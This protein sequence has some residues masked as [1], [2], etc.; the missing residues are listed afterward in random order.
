MKKTYDNKG[1]T[2]VE[3]IVVITI[4]AILWTIAFV[5]F[6]SYIS[7][8]RDTKRVSD[9]KVIEKWLEYFAI[10][11]NFYPNPTNWVFI[12]YSWAIVWNQWT[13]WNTTYQNID[14]ITPKPVDPITWLEYT[15]SVNNLKTEYQLAW[16]LEN[17]LSYNGIIK[18][19]YA[20]TI[21]TWLWFVRWNYNWKYLTVTTW[22]I[23]YVLA[24][25]SIISSDLSQT[26]VNQIVS[27]KNLVFNYY[28]NLP[29][30]YK[31]THYIM[32]GW[33]NYNPTDIVLFKWS[34]LNLSKENEQLAFAT[35]LKNVYGNSIFANE[36]DY[37]V[38]K[39][40]NPTINPTEA[41]KTVQSLILN[42]VW[43][44]VIPNFINII[45]K[46]T[47]NRYNYIKVTEDSISSN[48]VYWITQDNSN[49]FW[50]ATVWWWISKFDWRNWN[51][52]TTANNSQLPSNT[53]YWTIKD[54]NWNIWFA[55]SAGLVKYNWTTWIKYT[56][57]STSGWLISNTVYA[58]TQDS[59]WSIWVWTS[60]W[61]SKF[62]GT[63]WTVY[64]NA[65]TS[66]WLANNTVN[67]IT[68]WNNWEIWFA[69]N[70]WVSRFNG[71]TWT[72]YNTSN[73]SSMIWSNTTRHIIKDT[74]WN[75]WVATASW[76]SKYNWTIWSKFTTSNSP[77]F[78][79]NSTRYVFQ[80]NSWNIWIATT[81]WI[82]MYNWSVWVKY[83]TT[84]WLVLN[85][86]MR[87]YQDNVWNIRFGTNW[88][89][90]S[91]YDWISWKSIIKSSSLASNY[92]NT[93]W[94]QLDTT[95][96]WFGTNDL[97]L[98]KL[99]INWNRTI[100]DSNTP[101]FT[102]NTIYH[103]IKDT[104][105]NIWVA[106]SAGICKRNWTAWT[107]YTTMQWLL[108]NS[109]YWV[110]KDTAWIMWI[111]T[112]SGL[113]SYNWTAFINYTTTHGLSVNT[114]RFVTVDSSW[115][116]WIATTNGLNKYNKLTNKFYII[117]TS[118]W[119]ASNSINKIHFEWWNIW[120]ATNNWVSKWI[121]Q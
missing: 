108:N 65:N 97:W 120:L 23:S 7:W 53:I 42:R 2:L 115:D 43:W 14:G 26:D 15:Y 50:F 61:V 12:T 54:S 119:I 58:L 9:V 75:I 91:I 33:V 21:K 3:L 93:V 72:I 86:V 76:L 73:T 121:I 68:E 105:N 102:A 36:S 82:S 46:P 70:S 78:A 34:I 62:N 18:Q 20:D 38:F 4:L 35:K 103:I 48:T 25:P 100:Y 118:V 111:A 31:W 57:A 19:S 96:I 44:I 66:G 104:V 63:V 113:S 5:S 32:T 28:K 84:Q 81:T 77:N 71:T 101:N 69:T 8:T 27:N 114:T 11:K 106:T 40:L 41:K 56:N 87:I 112:N 55:T 95:W 39:K 24:L 74:I 16:M 47:I 80:D 90:I 83:T 49:N 59:S 17:Q 85:D 79:W 110:V 51:L 116:I 109:T 99:N 67:S 37:K 94:W 89:G 6:Q 64:T 45:N 29:A 98:N 52:Y 1:F 92:I 107:K 22:S 88:G 10:Q 60:A 117:D 13:F 30:N